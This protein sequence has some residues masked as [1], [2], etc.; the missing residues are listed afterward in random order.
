MKW[1]YWR[2]LLSQCCTMYNWSIFYCLKIS[3]FKSF[4][5]LCVLN[6]LKTEIW[7]VKNTI[8]DNITY[9]LFPMDAFV[10]NYAQNFHTITP[11]GTIQFS[12]S[13]HFH[14]QWT[15]QSLNS[16]YLSKCAFP[17]AV[18]FR[19]NYSMFDRLCMAGTWRGL[20]ATGWTISCYMC[21]KSSN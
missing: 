14:F 1:Q 16:Q 15:N 13:N 11:N 4:Y 8:I 20:Y 19:T 17:V 21:E 6:S 10:L 2:L 18:I 9:F 12:I 3:M 7:M 5:Y